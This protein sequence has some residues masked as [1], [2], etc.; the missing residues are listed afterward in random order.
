MVKWLKWTNIRNKWPSYQILT[1]VRGNNGWCFSVNTNAE[2]TWTL[3]CGV[4]ILNSSTV[5]S[6]LILLL[7][8]LGW[9]VNAPDESQH[10]LI[11]RQPGEQCLE[12]V[13]DHFHS[14]LVLLIQHNNT[15][16]K[17]SH[18]SSQMIMSGLQPKQ[19]LLKYLP[20]SFPFF[21]SL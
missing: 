11:P 17:L 14:S 21:F 1:R 3:L 12:V 8:L 19:S 10:Y 5:L 18:C 13:G 15:V 4:R 16:S 9:L 2:A 20:F 7:L 6:S